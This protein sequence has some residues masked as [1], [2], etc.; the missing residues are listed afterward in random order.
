MA[1]H[2]DKSTHAEA[3]APAKGIRALLS[4]RNLVALVGACMAV[5]SFALALTLTLRKDEPVVAPPTLEDALTSLE[6]GEFA[7]AREIAGDLRDTGELSFDEQGGPLYILGAALVEDIEEQWSPVE[8]QRLHMIA[9]RYLEEARIQGFPEGHEANGLYLLA[10][11]LFHGGRNAD[12][13]TVLPEALQA[14]PSHRV[15]LL[16]LLSLAH[17]RTPDPNWRTA[18]EFNQQLLAEPELAPESQQAALLEQ[19]QILLQ[20]GDLAGSRAALDSVT[21]PDLTDGVALMRGRVLLAEGDQ[22]AADPQATDASRDLARQKYAEAILA[23]SGLSQDDLVSNPLA[24]AARLVT[25]LAA[26]RAG[27]YSEAET[28]LSGIRRLDLQTPEAFAASLEEA[29]IQRHLGK[30]DDAV[31]SYQRTLQEANQPETYQNPWVPLAQLR[32]RVIAAYDAYLLGKD[33]E[34]AIALATPPWPPFPPASPVELEAAAERAWAD[35]LNTEASQSN[36]PEAGTL[37]DEA[38]RHLRQAGRAFERL[39]Q[40]RRASRDYPDDLWRSATCFLEGHDYE[41]AAVMLDLY[42]KHSDRRN[43]PRALVALG[44]ANLALQRLDG[45]LVPLRECVQFNPRHPDSYRA[46]LLAAQ[47]HG[48]RGELE[49][50]RA[51]L[52]QN[53]EQ[54]EL[55]TS[56]IEWRASMFALGELLHRQATLLEATGRAQFI[57][58]T[59]PEDQA[60][61]LESLDQSYRLFE[62]AID[63]FY[64]LQQAEERYGAGPQSTHARYLAADAHRQA[65]R[66]PEVRLSTAAVETQRDDLVAQRTGH[67]EAAAPAYAQLIASLNREEEQRELTEFE[68]AILRN[69]YFARAHVLYDLEQYPEAVE[70]YSTASNRYQSEPEA[71]EALVQIARCYR[72]MDR[73]SDARGTL[74]QARIV[75]G[76]MPENADFK[77][78]TRQDR[79]EW[80]RTL[81]WMTNL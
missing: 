55:Q 61:A 70:A 23:L 32:S 44:E 77:R 14:D 73:P 36:T 80:E 81:D 49:E 69:C 1:Q 8:R 3:P 39:A 60:P 38:R 50:A 16:A 33:Y 24:R 25:G 68:R 2:T 71:L 46:R 63:T 59:R 15:E 11:S 42:R 45:A 12:C 35:E 64:K 74:K 34:H 37:R 7:E 76:R 56:S 6:A 58:S 43:D 30:H 40:L 54:G 78:T 72:Q 29:E 17:Q 41:R 4:K 57:K 66:W 62:T 9:A 75:L 22:L 79:Q 21:H 47:V 53:L 26:R 48:E 13:L 18:L 10:T 51:W 31:A 67:L 52:E 27:D 19:A 28:I 65:A 5:V 20:L